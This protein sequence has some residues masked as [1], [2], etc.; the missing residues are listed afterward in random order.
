MKKKVFLKKVSYVVI[1]TLGMSNLTGCIGAIWTLMLT[2]GRTH[3]R[4]EKRETQE[5]AKKDV[6]LAA[7]TTE[8]KLDFDLYYLPRYQI[9]SRSIK[10]RTMKWNSDGRT[11]PSLP[12]IVGAFLF[13][14]FMLSK[15]HPWWLLPNYS[16]YIATFYIR[17]HD[18][19]T[20]WKPSV[21]N[22][23]P[24]NPFPTTPSPSPSPNSNIKA[25]IAP[26]PPENLSF[27]R[28]SLSAEFP[29]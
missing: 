5:L 15:Y 21:Q 28:V 1:V 20:P 26:T 18:S 19:P 29:A 2:E 4:T 16:L 23:A 24:P 10:R 6:T 11:A 3:Y 8:E 27:R 22:P 14:S 13:E 12:L 9:Q 7:K 17:S 25:R